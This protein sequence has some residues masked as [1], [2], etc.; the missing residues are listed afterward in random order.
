MFGTALIYINESNMYIQRR[1][2]CSHIAYEWYENTY[3][4]KYEVLFKY[5]YEWFIKY[6]SHS[7]LAVAMVD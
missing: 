1:A 3:E 4:L 2:V 5:Y 6:K 7:K